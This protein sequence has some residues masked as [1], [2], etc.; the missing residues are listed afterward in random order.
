MSIENLM[1]TAL[2]ADDLRKA[3]SALQELSEQS[4]AHEKRAQ[5]TN[6]L[7]EQ[8]EHGFIPP[9]RSTREFE[10]KIASLMKQDLRVVA[11]AMKLATAP[12]GGTGFGTLEEGIGTIG[13]SDAS[14]N[15]QHALMEA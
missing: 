15:F 7:F 13:G 11:E 8:V 4:V 6:I 14:T 2:S 12:A 9:P 10:T 5:A 3:A 1:E